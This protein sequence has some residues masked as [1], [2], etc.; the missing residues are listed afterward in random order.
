LYIPHVYVDVKTEML[1]VSPVNVMIVTQEINNQQKK[2]VDIDRKKRR[3]VN[4]M[5][6]HLAMYLLAGISALQHVL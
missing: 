5:D 3:T 2:A 6:A 4:T 1:S